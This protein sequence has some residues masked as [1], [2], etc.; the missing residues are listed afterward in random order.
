LILPEAHVVARRD[1]AVAANIVATG[2]RPT[3]RS[4]GFA[5]RF[6]G[7]RP[8]TSLRAARRTCQ[9]LLSSSFRLPNLIA[10]VD[11][12]FLQLPSETPIVPAERRLDAIQVGLN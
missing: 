9:C 12:Q 1:P 4:A 8:G 3:G 2:L 5:R 10:L 6:Q 7:R 11:A